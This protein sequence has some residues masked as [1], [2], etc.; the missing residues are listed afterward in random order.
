MMNSN[1]TAVKKI[2][3]FNIFAFKNEQVKGNFVEPGNDFFEFSLEEIGQSLVDRFETQAERYPGNF[4]VVTGKQKFTYREL[5]RAANRI[6]HTLG[7][8]CMMWK[9]LSQ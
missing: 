8:V 1:N 6:A 9:W 5:N 7:T 4:A 2:K 3:D